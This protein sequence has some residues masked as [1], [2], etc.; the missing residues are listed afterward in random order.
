MI[1]ESSTEVT[2]GEAAWLGETHSIK[3]EGNWAMGCHLASFAGFLIPFGNILG[4]LV[5]WLVKK[6]KCH[7]VAD[8]GKEVLNFQITVT[9]M[10]LVASLLTIIFLGVLLLV[11]LVIYWVVFTIIGTIRANGGEFYRYPFTLRLIK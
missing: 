1:E 4:P 10:A 7:R 11:A 5:V 3:A 9:F 2:T 6:E 8:Q